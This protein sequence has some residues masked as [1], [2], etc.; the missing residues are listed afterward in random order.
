MDTKM[1]SKEINIKRSI[2]V[3]LAAFLALGSFLNLI[4]PNDYAMA[5]SITQHEG[6]D[7]AT[8]VLG[9]PW[10]MEEFSDIGTYLNN[11]NQS[12]FLTNVSVANGTFSATS[13][14]SDPQ[15]TLLFPGYLG[16]M[17]LGKVGANYPI[18]SSKYKC[19]Y[20]AM[21]VESSKPDYF[22]VYWFANN[23]LNG[24]S[25]GTTNV[26]MNL[27]LGWNLYSVNLANA[28]NT[29]VGNTRWSDYGS[30]QGLRIDPSVRSSS[31][32][33][34]W[35]RLTDC[36]PVDFR[37]S[38]LPTN[39]Y[40]ILFFVK[41]GRE[42]RVSNPVQ[43]STG[44]YTFDLQGIEPGSYTYQVR[45]PS[46]NVVS[47]GD[48]NINQS[49][50]A[51]FVNPSGWTGQDYSETL[52]TPWDMETS[53]S[54]S[55]INC[56]SSNFSNG[57]LNI[58]TKSKGSLP[59]SCVSGGYA[60][61]KIYLTSLSQVNS[62][63]YRYLNFK[64]NADGPW[65]DVPNGMIARFI[66]TIKGSRPGTECS[67]VSEDIAFGVGTN[68]YTIDLFD[69]YNG[70]IVE[71][72]GACSSNISSWANSGTVVSFRFDPNENQLG[73]DLNQQIDWIRLTKEES[74]QIGNRFSISMNLNKSVD[75]IQSWNFYYTTTPS[76][77]RQNSA[78]V[79][80]SATE[81]TST[82]QPVG[83]YFTFLPMI[84]SPVGF[85]YQD[86]VGDVTFS[87]NTSGA[88]AGEYYLC[89][90]LND[91]LNSNIFCSQA[92]VILY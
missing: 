24:G 59:S 45:T 89:A 47:S 48:V 30:W 88:S 4:S 34:D 37:V 28:N 8:Q 12:Q 69:A 20:M 27:D 57:L 41:D 74:V 82:Q 16:A 42:I 60:D 75:S 49:P 1:L 90:E 56:S 21:D 15:F 54:V 29:F 58:S 31:F 84:T 38:G 19:L 73:R 13:V 76:Q 65:E 67:M 50:I 39:S 87:W 51:Q 55:R 46:G 10:D 52:S 79:S 2:R 68:T 85:A 6:N 25:W 18:D 9:D 78:T 70:Q 40:L 5:E 83:N 66:W 86:G 32:S 72:S 53:Q 63:Q 71:R 62:S 33:V 3:L 64:M 17:A 61:P 22:E 14:G 77:P 43:T 92:P 11:S 26:L 36:Q 91:G 44:S 35:V 81:Q 7:F 23:Y 80:L